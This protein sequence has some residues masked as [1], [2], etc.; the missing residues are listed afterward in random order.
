VQRAS[1]LVAAFAQ[2]RLDLLTTAMQDRMHQP[3]RME[4]CPL[5]KTLLPLADEPEIAGVALSGAGPSVLIFLAEGTT[6]LAAETRL[7][8]VLEPAV[9]IVS[10]RIGEGVERTLL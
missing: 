5:L 8:A 6:I 2:G 10:L 1:L 4:A 7:R 9:E 3:Y